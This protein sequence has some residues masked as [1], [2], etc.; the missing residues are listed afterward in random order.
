MLRH[1]STQLLMNAKVR[2]LQQDQWPK[3]K[4]L[5]K[6][7]I[8]T[9]RLKREREWDSSSS[10]TKALDIPFRF[11]STDDAVSGPSILISGPTR[12]SGDCREIHTT[13]ASV[14]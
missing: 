10:D 14:D 12:E 3:R 4:A 1:V 7:I 9:I 2:Q 6:Q 5:A 8:K 13:R 11:L